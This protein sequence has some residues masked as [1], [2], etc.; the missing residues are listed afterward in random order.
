METSW[1]EL[2]LYG[3]GVAIEVLAVY[4]ATELEWSLVFAQIE[5]ERHQDLSNF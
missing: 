5:Q 2:L 4:L 1:S 3:A